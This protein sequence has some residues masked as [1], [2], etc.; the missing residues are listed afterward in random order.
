MST[1]QNKQL[2]ETIFAE[3]LKGNDTP[4]IDAMA[5]DMQWT[6]MG[7]GQ[8]AKTFSGK[9]AVV[10][11]LWAAVKTTIRPPFRVVADRILADG[12][13]VVI[14][15]RGHNVTPEGKPY[16]NTYCWVCRVTDGK[17]REL[18]EY[19]DTDLVTA[20]FQGQ[21]PANYLSR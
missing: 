16:N 7:S 18:R 20:T 10:D 9:Q 5:E 1:A 2:L 14:E 6:W 8:W 3:L 4:F 12:D 19:M 15:A 13:W 21:R 11:E 17:L